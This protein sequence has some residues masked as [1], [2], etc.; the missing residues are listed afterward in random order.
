MKKCR[1]TKNFMLLVCCARVWNWRLRWDLPVFILTQPV[2]SIGHPPFLTIHT[3]PYQATIAHPPLPF[4]P[5]T[6][7]KLCP[8]L[9]PLFCVT[10]PI[11]VCQKTC[12]TV[13]VVRVSTWKVQNYIQASNHAATS[14]STFSYFIKMNT[15]H[16]IF[17]ELNWIKAKLHLKWFAIPESQCGCQAKVSYFLLL[18]STNNSSLNE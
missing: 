18:Q 17:N 1:P 14:C 6:N 16:Y 8:S 12:R 7:G 13:S 10:T 15:R 11:I 9:A 2:R 4:P 3:N 5:P